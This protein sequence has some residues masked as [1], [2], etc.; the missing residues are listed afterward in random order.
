MKTPISLTTQHDVLTNITRKILDVRNQF[1][2]KT[3]TY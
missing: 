3:Q 2:V 1:E